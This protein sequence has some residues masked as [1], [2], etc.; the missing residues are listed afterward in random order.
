MRTSYLASE[1]I[2]N[3]MVYVTFENPELEYCNTYISYGLLSLIGEIGETL[4][5]RIGES[6][7]KLLD[8]ILGLLPY[9]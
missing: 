4:G 9:Y 6:I 1:E 3:T 2:K 8:I 7:M 5:L